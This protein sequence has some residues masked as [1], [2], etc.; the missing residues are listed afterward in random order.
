MTWLES[1]GVGIAAALVAG[2]LVMFVYDYI[3]FRMGCYDEFLDE[4]ESLGSGTPVVPQEEL[5]VLGLRDVSVEVLEKIR[6]EAQAE[7]FR[8][9]APNTKEED[10]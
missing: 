2:A 7:L 6:D 3:R 5:R 9:N 1:A 4:D 8:R 10:E